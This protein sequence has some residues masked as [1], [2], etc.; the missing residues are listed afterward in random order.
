MTVEEA[1]WAGLV[2]QELELM[3]VNTTLLAVLA[4][5]VCSA[6]RGV[7]QRI[8]SEQVLRLIAVVWLDARDARPRSLKPWWLVCGHSRL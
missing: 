5:G 2:M 6:G 1:A 7:P 3:A 4:F 8:A